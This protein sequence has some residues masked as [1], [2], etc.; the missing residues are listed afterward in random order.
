MRNCDAGSS[1]TASSACAQKEQCGGTIGGYLCASGFR[2]VYISCSDPFNIITIHDLHESSVEYLTKYRPYT[3]PADLNGCGS[4][5]SSEKQI[6]AGRVRIDQDVV[7]HFK[8]Y[9]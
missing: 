4:I 6:G 7:C 2:W 9:Y 5:G 1:H 3:I 8:K